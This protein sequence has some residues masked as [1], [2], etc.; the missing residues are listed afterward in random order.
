MRDII[1]QIKLIIKEMPN[2]IV[3]ALEN[4]TTNLQAYD[5][6]CMSLDDNEIWLI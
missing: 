2:I 4:T 5:I 3:E 6:K 1:R